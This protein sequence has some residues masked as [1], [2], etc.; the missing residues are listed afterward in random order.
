MSEYNENFRFEDGVL[1]VRLS[2]DFPNE[3]FGKEENLFQPLIDACSTYECK[4]ALVDARDLKVD[5]NTL[6]IFQA[7]VDAAFVSRRGI[8][9]ALV[10][11]EAMLDP[12]FDHVVYNRGGIVG[13]FM[14]TDS[15]LDWLQE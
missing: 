4:K 9:L 10:A 3:L 1:Y 13:I 2:G 6:A 7:G 15:A 14:D 12:F 5:F 11:T 8:R